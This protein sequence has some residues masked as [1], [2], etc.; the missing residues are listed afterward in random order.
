M[1]KSRRRL[2]FF[3]S[4]CLK[5]SIPGG[6][7][8]IFLWMC[9]MFLP[10]LAAAQQQKVTIHVNKGDV[11]EVFRQIKEQTKLNFVYNAEQLKPLSEVT[12]NVEN[13][14]VDNALK[15][16]FAGTTFEYKFEMQSI[17]IR[18][19]TPRFEQ[20]R[21]KVD[22]SVTDMQGN[23]LPGVSVFL[24][25]TTVGTTTRVDGGFT[26]LV[27]DEEN[28]VLV[29]SFIGMKRQEVAV[30]E[31]EPIKVKMEEESATLDEVNVISTGY[32]N[33]DKRHLTSSVT[34]IKAEDIMMPGVSTIDQ[35][36]ESNVPGMMYL[37]NSGQVGATPKLKIRGNT[38][39][40]G[41]QAPLWV[42]DGVIL[43]DPVNIDPN[44]LNSL[45]FVNLLGNAISGVNPDDI[46]RID[47]L[48]DASATAI[49]G[50]KASNGVIVITTK[51]GKSGAPSVSY[52]VTGSFRRRPHYTDKAVNVMNSMERIDFSREVVEK[53]LATGTLSGMIGYEGAALEY[54]NG[55]ISLDEFNAKVA[56]METCNTDWFGILLKNSFSHNH[57]LSI[58]GGSDHIRYYAS[59]GYNDENGNIRKESSKRYSAMA[60]INLNYNKFMM[61]FQLSGNL[62]KKEYTPS[63]VGLM[64]YAYNTSRSI[65]AY[66]PDGSLWFYDRHK[67][68]DSDGTGNY[69]QPFSIINERD[70]SYNK[71]NTDG[72]SLATM[73]SYK[74][75]PWLKADVQLS[76]SVSHSGNETWFG[77]NTYYSAALRK[78][79]KEGRPNAGEIHAAQTELPKGGELRMDDTK[80]ETYGVRAQ[81]T[82]NDFLDKDHNHQLTISAIGDL[83]SARY[84]GLKITRRGYYPDRGMIF[85][86]I[87]PTDVTYP[88][89]NKW[90]LERPEARGVLKDNLTNQVGL[91]GTISYVYKDSYIL[92]ANARVD[93]SNKFG[94]KSNER[95]LPIW[96]VSGRWNMHENIL[97]NATK[98]NTLA[99]KLSFG[100]QGNMSAQD[101][102]R[103]V[104]EKKGMDDFFHEYYSKIK[105]YP[106][107]NLRW[108]R[109][110]TFNADVEFSF[111]NNKLNGSV[112]YYYRHTTDAFLSKTVSFVNGVGKYTV[113]Q[114]TLTNQGYELTLNFVPINT[115]TSAGGSNRGFVWRFDPNFGSVFNQLIDKL[116]PKDA[117]LQDEIKYADYLN[118][119]VQVAGRPLNTFYSYRY[120]G[121]NHN[122][123]RPEFYN[124]EEELKEK[125]A[126]MSKEE[127]FQTV[128]VHSGCREPFL[129]GG[130]RNYFGWRNLGLTLNLA[131][132]VGAKIRLLKMYPNVAKVA[133]GPETNMRKEFVNRWRRPGDELNT[134]VPG[135]LTNAEFKE[136][137][138]KPWWRNFTNEFAGTIWHMYDNSDLRVVS[139]D[140]L[141]LQNVSLRYVIP[142]SFCKKMLLKSAYV[143]LSGTNL[144]TVCSRKLKGQDPSQ[145]G[146]SD[147]VNLSIRPMYSFQL[148]VT[149]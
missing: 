63:E 73:L 117:V 55:L 27:P 145:S 83:N 65:R 118:G 111:F 5:F 141:R 123:G 75:T 107:P 109:T 84:S 91:I 143:S 121:L 131:Y 106:N 108:E 49:Y 56:D 92:N 144:F 149:F 96:S 15:S 137:L 112:G 60:K 125:Y 140:Y 4:F 97:K 98:V 119:S 37:Q 46:D 42:L 79:F 122:D 44:E 26:F 77:E 32:Y 148:N 69:E 34:S 54:Y 52:S 78:R 128:M 126:G 45:D 1:K 116:K 80:N 30:K 14:T 29:F 19:A 12:L 142:Q 28:Q 21:F 85:D 88:A 147:L 36:L 90:L 47:V 82:Y 39:V 67:D 135:L 38:T 115:A 62:Q 110:S 95:L 35:M 20:K 33:V 76:Y 127:V 31:G 87:N 105:Q 139:G 104:I 136:T 120:K 59:L 146:S 133:P 61:S 10:L 68:A 130:I 3:S 24:K 8:V 51:K 53:R 132:S 17:V 70:N 43:T 94:D 74:V 93:A 72:I 129:Q 64:D 124:V 18:K 58:S 81:L 11:Q 113:N 102:P 25:G 103:L 2:D 40:L 6:G 99:L 100:Y 13:V 138:N 86:I 7:Q 114:G 41:S 48:K 57:T 23:P 50:P 66:N 71:I 134:D 9:L 22:G 16:L 89:Y 101:S